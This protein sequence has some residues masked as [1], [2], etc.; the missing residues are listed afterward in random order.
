MSLQVELLEQ[1]FALVKPQAE[2]FA[3]SFYENLFAANPRLKPLFG[4]VDMQKQQQKLISALV[5]VVQS[6]RKPEVLPG[7]LKDLGARH[8][9]YGAIPKYFPLVSSALLVTLEQYIQPDWT[10]EVKQAWVDALRSITN[11]MFEGAGYPP[12]D[13]AVETAPIPA[14]VEQK[15]PP[16]SPP[17]TAPAPVLQKPPAL[18]KSAVLQVELLESSFA[19]VRPKAAQFAAS[20]YE[21]LFAANPEVKPLFATVDMQKQQQKLVSTLV[22]VIQSLRKPEVLQGVLKDLG[23]RH[24]A[25]GAIPKYYPLVSSALLVTLKQYLPQDWTEEVQQAWVNAFSV[26]T[27]VMLEGAGY[28][29]ID[30]AVE[31]A[32]I[33]API[34][35]TPTS[36][37]KEPSPLASAALL[38]NF[39]QYLQQKDLTPEARQACLDAIGVINQVIFEG[40]KYVA[41]S[42][43]SQLVPTSS[44]VVDT[45]QIMSKS[46][47]LPAGSII[48][49]EFELIKTQY[50]RKIA[51]LI[52][53]VKEAL[54]PEK[55]KA[56]LTEN[57]AKLLQLFWKLP[58]WAIA[59]V[60]ALILISLVLIIDENSPFAKILGTAD[61]ISVLLAL[62]L[63][64]KEI[65]ERRKQSHYQAWSIIDGAEGVEASYA[66]LMAMQDLNQDG[67]SL[68]GVKVAGAKLENIDLSEAIL[69]E[70]DFSKADLDEANLSRANLKSANLSAANLSDANLSGANLEDATLTGANLEGAIMPDDFDRK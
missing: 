40:G 53:I 47:D 69:T 6:L 18:Q 9:A 39:E 28:S 66:R 26:I 45:A 16:P 24:I 20:F 57:Q 23:A 41:P 33:P 8:I 37:Q 3:A 17:P 46:P 10:A 30:V 61:A 59:G 63:F 1:S 7:V 31:T 65:P 67:V 21:N 32:P 52:S 70:A 27:N 49:H 38:A 2:Q 11:L 25:Y 54:T 64:I 51:R 36:L 68:R 55:I 15:T 22:L 5:L 42:A 4:T 62:I 34:V 43:R 35:Q 29:P 56:T 19:K 48:K 14:P 44:K 12:L 60:A 58:T 50:H 13:V